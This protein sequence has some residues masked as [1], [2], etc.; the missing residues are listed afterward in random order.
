MDGR[1]VRKSRDAG[2]PGR[3]RVPVSGGA[4]A[5]GAPPDTGKRRR[6]GTRKIFSAPERAELLAAYAAWKGRQADFCAAHGVSAGSL[7]N[8]RSRV[9]AGGQAALVP[10]R[11]RADKASRARRVVRRVSS[12]EERRAAPRAYPPDFSSSSNNPSERMS[13]NAFPRSTTPGRIR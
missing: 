1:T 9:A 5:A 11:A 3:G 4:P 2:A 12:P 10:L 6:D 8:W 7:L 13:A